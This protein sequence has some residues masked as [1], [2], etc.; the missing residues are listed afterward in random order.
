MKPNALTAELLWVIQ[1]GMQP[2]NVCLW[3]RDPVRGEI[4]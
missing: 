3:L 2:E 4:E 1:K